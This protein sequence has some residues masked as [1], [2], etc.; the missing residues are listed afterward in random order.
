MRWQNSRLA[1]L[2][3]ARPRLFIAIAIAVAVGQFLPLSVASDTITRWLVAWNSGT[4]S[5]LV[6]AVAMMKR[7]TSRTMRERALQQD[8]S[9]GIILGL[10]VISAIA[11]LAAIAVELSVARALSNWHKNAHMALA[12][13]TVLL[14]WAFI[15]IMF[16]LHYAH[17][18]FGKRAT[19]KPGL[20]FPGD[21]E[22]D[23]FDFLYFSASIGTSGQTAD[24]SFT[25]KHMRHIGTL[26]CVLAYLFNTVVLALL[27]NIGAGLI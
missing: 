21:E 9:Q 14:T 1:R 3:W 5:Y 4:A 23:Y 11:S 6:F 15:Q 19:G 16:A 24:V 25:S 20:L 17:E 10:I 27:I 2:V 22:P 26:H 13:L 8:E 18:Y 7:S 12:G